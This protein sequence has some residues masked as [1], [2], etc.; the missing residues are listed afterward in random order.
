MF[1]EQ[2]RPRP[3]EE[4]DET[5]TLLGFQRATLSGSAAAWIRLE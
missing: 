3:P 1:D 4:A 5:D 2:G